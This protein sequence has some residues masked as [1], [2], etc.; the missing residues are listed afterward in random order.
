MDRLE[1]RFIIQGDV[2]SDYRTYAA[3]IFCRITE[4]IGCER[5]KR[6]ASPGDGRTHV[7]TAA[8]T[9]MQASNGHIIHCQHALIV[10]ASP[11]R[12]AFL[13]RSYLAKAIYA[14]RKSMIEFKIFSH[15]VAAAWNAPAAFSERRTT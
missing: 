14:R 11:Y 10:S 6:P 7:T 2:S 4:H 8:A 5:I 9:F 12:L 1:I 15:S 3:F 13:R